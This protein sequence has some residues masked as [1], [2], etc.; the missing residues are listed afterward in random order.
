LLHVM[1]AIRKDVEHYELDH[2][3]AP[4]IAAVTRLVQN[5]TI[6]VHSPFSFASEQ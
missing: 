2:Y 3:F 6:A 5:G 4:D 1:H